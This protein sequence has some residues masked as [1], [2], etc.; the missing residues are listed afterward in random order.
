MGKWRPHLIKSPFDDFYGDGVVTWWF[1]VNLFVAISG[2][3]VSYHSD[4]C[5]FMWRCL[6]GSGSKLVGYS[7]LASVRHGQHKELRQITSA[8]LGRSHSHHF[9]CCVSW[10]PMDAPWPVASHGVCCL[11]F[12]A[13]S[14][15]WPSINL[16]GYLASWKPQG[17]E[18]EK[19]FHFLT[20]CDL[21][22]CPQWALHTLTIPKCCCWTIVMTWH[23]WEG[24]AG[25]E[26][27]LSLSLSWASRSEGSSNRPPMTVLHL[28]KP[29][30]SLLPLPI[31]I[32][33][34]S[35]EHSNKRNHDSALFPIW[36]QILRDFRHL[37]QNQ[38]PMTALLSSHERPLRWKTGN[39]APMVQGPALP[40]IIREWPG[41]G[42]SAVPLKNLENT[43][44]YGW[45]E[46][47]VEPG[48][49]TSIMGYG[50]MNR[51]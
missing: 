26:L 14:T 4:F 17:V 43:E 51:I 39:F 20:G 18:L 9:V 29:A 21:C 25:L 48:P 36:P 40:S 16:R 45:D 33:E 34:I 2:D 10:R 44:S 27:S 11:P 37:P 7:C 6:F 22:T 38:C 42:P 49:G 47:R 1:M 30:L 32:S 50:H 19:H 5:I 12:S 8:P 3:S 28:W 24:L 23:S 31:W 46:N 41:R 35:M 13:V 15:K